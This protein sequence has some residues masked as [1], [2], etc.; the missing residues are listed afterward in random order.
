MITDRHLNWE[1]IGAIAGI[2]GAVAAMIALFPMISS[3]FH[4]SGQVTDFDGSIAQTAINERGYD[5][6]GFSE[7][8]RFSMNDMVSYQFSGHYI[9]TSGKDTN[10]TNKVCRLTLHA[11]RSSSLPYGGENG[12]VYIQAGTD[13]HPQTAILH[14]PTIDAIYRKKLDF[15][16]YVPP[17][18]WPGNYTFNS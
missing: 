15:K 18:C 2:F 11:N 14:N 12:F 1:K 6:R 17:E 5:K 10:P 9:D 4:G 8:D 7:Q 3:A 13:S 16:E